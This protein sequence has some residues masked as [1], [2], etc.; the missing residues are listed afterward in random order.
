[1]GGV[2]LMKSRTTL[3]ETGALKVNVK[4]PVI[5]SGDESTSQLKQ[6]GRRG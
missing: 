2:D 4:I 6:D 1:M 5:R 3:M